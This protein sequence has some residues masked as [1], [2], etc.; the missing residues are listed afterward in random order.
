MLRDLVATC[1][2][3]DETGSGDP[4]RPLN[5]RNSSAVR[6]G[7][8]EKARRFERSWRGSRPARAPAR[9]LLCTKPAVAETINEGP[10]T[11][12]ALRA[13]VQ[14]IAE[15]TRLARIRWCDGSEEERTTLERDMALSGSFI[16]LD[17]QTPPRSFLHRSDPTDVART[18]HLTFIS[19]PPQEIAGPT[20]HWMGREL[21]KAYLNAASFEGRSDLGVWR[22]GI[23]RHEYQEAYRTEARRRGLL[24]RLVEVCTEALCILPRAE[25]SSPEAAA[26]LNQDTEVLLACPGAARGVLHRGSAL[27][28]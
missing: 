6:R 10:T 22:C 24:D 20:N 26:I 7:N 28:H 12:R 27:R 13:W 2:P 5:W 16:E 11:N 23:A 18:K 8:A 9:I 14:A 1:K 21:L 3:D 25:L 4:R 15:H 19:T 17:P